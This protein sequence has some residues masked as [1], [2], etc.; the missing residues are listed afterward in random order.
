MSKPSSTTLLY[1]S[2]GLNIILVVLIALNIYG[3]DDS[4]VVEN[5]TGYNRIAPGKASGAFRK[6]NNGGVNFLRNVQNGVTKLFAQ[7]KTKEAVA[8]YDYELRKLR[9]R[10]LEEG[11]GDLLRSYYGQ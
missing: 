8:K 7:G 1:L 9:Q 10:E 2:V 11:K 4:D 5:L 6:G 3:Q